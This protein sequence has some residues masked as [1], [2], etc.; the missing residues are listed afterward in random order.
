LETSAAKHFHSGSSELLHP[1]FS[2]RTLHSRRASRTT[3]GERLG[4]ELGELLGKRLSADAEKL[5][6]VTDGLEL[7]PASR[8]DN[9]SNT[10]LSVRKV[11]DEDEKLGSATHL[12]LS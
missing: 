10:E 5:S 8:S 11:S 7:S 9:S 3:V 6:A 4:H 2:L 1:A 12:A